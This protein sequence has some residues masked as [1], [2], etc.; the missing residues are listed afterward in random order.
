MSKNKPWEERK[1]CPVIILCLLFAMWFFI[2]PGILGIYLYIRNVMID[3]KS[4]NQVQ[5][6]TNTEERKADMQIVDTHICKNE[7]FSVENAQVISEEDRAKLMIP[8]K[9]YSLA[10]HYTDV[11]VFWE[12]YIP[13]D[14]K[15]GNRV[16][17]IQEPTNEFDNKAVLLMFVPQK[18]KFGYLHRGKL[19]DMANDYIN[20]GDKVTARVSYIQF[21]P[22]KTMKIDMAFFKKVNKK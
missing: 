22:Q 3:K 8:D 11:K 1:K 10:Y 16:I 4:K 21:K 2:V 15:A 17:L 9:G 12:D 19:Q 6:I 18:K 7:P 14:V 20:N 5:R 13:N